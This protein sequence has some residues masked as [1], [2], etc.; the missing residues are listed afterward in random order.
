MSSPINAIYH[1]TFTTNATP[2]P[3]TV[4]L[5][6]DATEFEII[7][8]TD[9]ETPAATVI[10]AKGYDASAAGYGVL[11]TGNGAT[12]NVLAETVIIADGFTFFSDS[13]ATAV[14]AATALNGTEISRAAI[15]VASTADTTTVPLAAGD[16]V[17]LYGTTG[18][19]QLAGMDFTVG[20]VNANTNFQLVYLNN[21]GW[22]ADAT[23][24]FW[25]K[26]PFSG[27]P[28][29]SGAIAPNPRLYPRNR[30]ITS[31][32]LAAQAVI[33]MS[34]AHAYVVGEYVNIIVPTEFG[35]VQMHN[36]VA[37]ITAVNYTTN[38]ITV[39]VN[40][41]GFTAFAFPTS[42]IA[43]NGVTFAQVVPVGEIT[44]DLN[45]ASRN[46]SI[47]GVI[48]GATALAASKSYAWIAKKGLEI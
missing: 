22:A 3:V 13:A 44:Y 24:G 34:V 39:D 31:I 15:A 6:A 29:A 42:A 8:L 28:L 36:K 19:L 41:T 1:G 18:M 47:R 27:V 32:S 23:A 46:V 2:S 26:L 11:K 45:D 30:Y 4:S 9:Y 5:P 35:M 37:K 20:T 38:S 43:A 16:V 40:S 48:I 33:I 7:N 10:I 12:P 14:S 25:M 21:A 17:R